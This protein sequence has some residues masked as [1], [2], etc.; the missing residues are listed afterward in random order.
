MFFKSEFIR[1][2][3]TALGA[4]AGLM[5]LGAA[6]PVSAT[7][8]NFETFKIRNAN[9]QGLT[10]IEQ[11]SAPFDA[12][13]SIVENAAGNGF[14]A[15]T[16]RAGQ[17][18]GYGTSFFNGTKL[19]AFQTVNW[20][21]VS[22]STTAAIPYLNFWVTDGINYA[23]IAAGDDYR[24]TDFLDNSTTPPTWN[25]YEFNTT[26]GDLNWLFGGSGTTTRVGQ[27]LL[28]DGDGVSLADFD[29]DVVLFEGAP[30]G[31]TGV[32]TGAPQGGFGFN[33]IFGD[34]QANYVGEYAIENLT[35]TVD[36]QV[37]A[38][39]VPEPGTLALFGIGLAGLG[40]IRRRTRSRQ[41]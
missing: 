5:M 19:N 28:L 40:A 29:D 35:V 14:A 39:G 15:M 13:L 34:T 37:F 1:L 30:F 7:V 16:P 31:S 23:V 32:G 20:D 3:A 21:K 27:R 26:V 17:K 41:R 11:I 6:A 12:D 8:I 38:A 24:G 18:V 22:G 2:K 33:V 36:G 9:G 4:V 10:P 25:V